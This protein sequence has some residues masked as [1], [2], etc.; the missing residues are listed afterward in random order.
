[1]TFEGMQLRHEGGL[2]L[3]AV[4]TKFGVVD[5][6]FGGSDAAPDEKQVQAYRRFAENL[7][8][9]IARLRK[10]IFFGFLWRPIRIAINTENR[11]GV[12]FRNRLTGNQGK[13][14]LEESPG[15]TLRAVPGAAAVSH[16]GEVIYNLLTPHMQQFLGRCVGAIKKAGIKAKGTGQFSVLLGDA[17]AE[18]RLDEFY[19]PAD[20]PAIVEKVVARA[21]ELVAGGRAL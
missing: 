11:V 2:W 7:D 12:Q 1:M 15:K 16:Q 9:N 20:D 21:R 4:S 13:L 8:A 19:E 5:V 14:I 18:L 6:L 10:Q 17:Q 3:G